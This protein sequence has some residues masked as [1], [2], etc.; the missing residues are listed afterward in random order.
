M[1]LKAFQPICTIKPYNTKIK[2]NITTRIKEFVFLVKRYLWQIG[3]GMQSV[4]VESVEANCVSPTK[5]YNLTL[6]RDNVYYANGV[7]VNNCADALMLTFT[8]PDPYGTLEVE[9]LSMSEDKS[10]NRYA[11]FNEL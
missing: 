6:D 10:F 7:L 4:A 2:Q 11:S 3:I 5:V 9:A 8:T 1:R